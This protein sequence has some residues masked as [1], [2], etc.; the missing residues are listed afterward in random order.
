MQNGDSLQ[1]LLVTVKRDQLG[2][3]GTRSYTFR[4][5]A[6]WRGAKVILHNY[7]DRDGGKIIASW[8]ESCPAIAT[9]QREQIPGVVSASN[10]AWAEFR[11][12]ITVEGF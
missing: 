2:V 5:Q 1:P 9:I 10:E 8:T 4:L 7:E 3:T 6:D 11:D 12:I